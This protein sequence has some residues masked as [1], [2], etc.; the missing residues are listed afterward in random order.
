[1]FGG[2]SSENKKHLKRKKPKLFIVLSGKQLK[3][4]R[5]GLSYELDFEK[6]ASRDSSALSDEP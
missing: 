6:R 3:A 1:M 4:R 2:E 5:A